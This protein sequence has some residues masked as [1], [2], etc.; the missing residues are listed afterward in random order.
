MNRYI[1]AFF[2]T[3]VC[4]STAQAT[5]T[6]TTAAHASNKANQA[7]SRAQYYNLL[8]LYDDAYLNS[9]ALYNKYQAYLAGVDARNLAKHAFE[10][11]DLAYRDYGYTHFGY[12]GR[13][14][15]YYAWLYANRAVPELWSIYIGA[16][17]FRQANNNLYW[18]SVTNGFATYFLV[19]AIT[20]TTP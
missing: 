7:L 14:Y 18:A 4:I 11:A 1:A 9:D 13:L 10:M 19:Y 17:Y 8:S 6:Y 20:P 15:A 3:L 12:Y 2:A 16:N 5:E